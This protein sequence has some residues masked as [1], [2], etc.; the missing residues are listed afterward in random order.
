MVGGRRDQFFGLG[1]AEHRLDARDTP[2]D[3]VA[4]P[5]QL[6]HALLHGFQSTRAKAVGRRVAVQFAQRSQGVPEVLELATLGRI[7]LFGV[8]PEGQDDFAHG[9]VA[10][11]RRIAKTAAAV[12]EPL[13]DEPVVFGTAL[14]RTP[15][16][17]VVVA[18]AKGDDGLSRRFVEA[19]RGCLEGHM[20]GLCPKNPVD[21]R[22]HKG[23]SAA[24]PT[25]GR[26]W[27]T[28]SAKGLDQVAAGGIEPPTRG[29]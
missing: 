14:R 10:A 3:D 22:L 6:D 24:L 27:K 16:A 20:C 29:L 9:E 26:F 17:Q 11:F 18:A 12:G 2:V 7:A 21:Y 1:P 28:S 23:I 25:V 4:A 15:L 13:G 19:I 8:L 5:S